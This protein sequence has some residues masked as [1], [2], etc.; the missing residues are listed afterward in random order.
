MLLTDNHQHNQLIY[1][2]PADYVTTGAVLTL[3]FFSAV[4][5]PA[6]ADRAAGT[7]VSWVP[8]G[9]R[10]GSKQKSYFVL[11]NMSYCQ[12]GDAAANHCCIAWTTAG[13]CMQPLCLLQVSTWGSTA[14]QATLCSMCSTRLVR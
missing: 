7:L 10:M 13:A 11:L 8:G 6:A 1:Q 12:N 14:E 4:L 2:T 9:V 5:A 3:A